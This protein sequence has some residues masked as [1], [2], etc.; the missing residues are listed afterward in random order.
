MTPNEAATRFF[1]SYRGRYRILLSFGP[2]G[3]DESR[4]GPFTVNRYRDMGD[5]RDMEPA[6]W[7]PGGELSFAQHT[8]LVYA[9]SRAKGGVDYAA[10]CRKH[11]LIGVMLITSGVVRVPDRNDPRVSLE[12]ETGLR[13]HFGIRDDELALVLIGKDGREYARYKPPA[14]MDDILAYIETLDEEQE[15]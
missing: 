10:E 14:V 5:F 11:E 8:E 7:Y 4:H 1:T 15:S 12:T 3:Y 2:A 6:P 9:A 13:E